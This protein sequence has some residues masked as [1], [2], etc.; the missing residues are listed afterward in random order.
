MG[1][2]QEL[3]ELLHS[4]DAA[5]RGRGTTIFISGEAGSGKTRLSNEFLKIAR[6]KGA[7]VLCG[8]CLSNSA[9][10]YF[11]FWESFSSFLSS[12]EASNKSF[13][14]QNLAANTWL[15]RQD[16]PQAVS[17]QAWQDKTFSV[18][19]K[20]LLFMSVDAPV[21]LFIDDLHW[22][23]SASLSLLHYVSRS[24]T[25]ERILIVGTFRSE[26]TQNIEG[27][28]RQLNETLRLMGREG[29]FREI[30]L[31][32]LNQADVGKIAESMLCGKVN[33]SLSEKLATESLG[34]P[35]YVV[36]SLRM[37]SDQGAIVQKNGRWQLSRK[38]NR[39]SRQS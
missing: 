16:N 11:P 12:S 1:R 30:K 38:R 15:V 24:T 19:A 10:P 22:A 14:D 5:T 26:E 23:D 37:L 33:I 7:S 8:W 35:L 18:I 36:E 25:S 28:G 20:E 2:S 34:L 17:A 29:L 39:Y 13:G 4:L 21:I 31:C 6:I 3:E 9:V 27:Y 32:G